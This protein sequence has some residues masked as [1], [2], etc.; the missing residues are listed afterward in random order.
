[1][2]HALGLALVEFAAAMAP[3][4]VAIADATESTFLKAALGSGVVSVFVLARHIY[5]D[6]QNWMQ[7]MATWAFVLLAGALTG[8]IVGTME[9]HC[10]QWRQ[11]IDPAIV[12]SGAGGVGALALWIIAE[13]AITAGNSIIRTVRKKLPD[14]IER[15]ISAKIPGAKSGSAVIP[16]G[17]NSGGTAKKDSDS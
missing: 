7:R 9:P 2:R 13:V 17:G 4:M 10:R 1:M 5:T 11:E 15:E 3:L 14:A 8:V 6:Q 12:Y 16:P